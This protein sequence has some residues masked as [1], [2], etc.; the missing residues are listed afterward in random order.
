[1]RKLSV[2]WVVVAS[3]AMLSAAP[4]DTLAGELPWSN[5]GCMLKSSPVDVPCP[6]SCDQCRKEFCIERVPVRECVKGK[7]LVYDCKVRSE[8]V[9]I[10]ETRY[11]WVNRCV[12]EEI[13]CC[14]C[15]PVCK[16]QEGVRGYESEEW[17]EDPLQTCSGCG[18]I[19][20]KHCQNKCEKVEC[21]HCAREPGETVIKVH[22]KSCV[23][24]AYVVYRQVRREVCVKKP[25]HEH[26]NVSITRY[27]CKHC[28]GN[29]CQ[30]CCD[31]GGCDPG[32]EHEGLQPSDPASEPA[33]VP[34]E[35]SSA[36]NLHDG[37]TP[38]VG[39]P[40][41]RSY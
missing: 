24:E 6:Q 18:G 40:G 32:C 29:G 26:V 38:G 1:M 28:N 35:D 11:R 37:I 7:K 9:T 16:T 19:Y 8:W 23:K 22:Y 4:Q 14:Y 34:E 20:C 30:T 15:K 13:P 25:R 21:K 17:S 10:P 12:T 27:E 5:L 39:R 33:P 31:P 36:W 41:T 3:A 2:L